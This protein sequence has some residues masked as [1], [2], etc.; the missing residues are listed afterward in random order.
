M[1]PTESEINNKYSELIESVCNIMPKSVQTKIYIQPW[2]M[3]DKGVCGYRVL[4]ISTNKYKREWI[5][6]TLELNEFYKIIYESKHDEIKNITNSVYN[7]AKGM[8]WI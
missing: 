3:I 1:I 8:R 2:S 6:F 4:L 7:R 5:Q